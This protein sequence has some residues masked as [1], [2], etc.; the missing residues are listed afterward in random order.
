MN[1]IKRLTF[2]L[3]IVALSVGAYFVK[4]GDTLWD[5]SAEFFND[6]FTWPDLW[7]NNRHIQ[8]PHWIYPGDSIYLGEAQLLSDSAETLPQ[9]KAKPCVTTAADTNLPKGVSGSTGCEGDDRGSSF[10]NMLGNLR[11][12]DK[13]KKLKDTSAKTAHYYQ[14]RPAPKI[15]NSYYQFNSPIVSSIQDL[16]NDDRWFSVSSGE[17]SKPLIYIPESELVVGIGRQIDKNLKKGD[18]IEIWDAKSIEVNHLKKY[19]FEKAALLVPSGYAKITAIGDTLSRAIIVQAFRDI[20]INNIK[21]RKKQ[22]AHYINVSGY[23]PIKEAAIEDMAY[24]RY[25]MDPSLI[26]GAY[27]Y[28]L[29]DKG[30]SSNFNSGDGVAIWEEDRSDPSIPPR[31]LGRG[32]ITFADQESST[33]LI[34]ETYSNSR[35][36]QIGHRVSITHA[37]QRVQ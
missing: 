35:R 7:E 6:P 28:I 36:I 9:A 26:I 37:A 19:G 2:F 21:A 32:V 11:E 16:K 4:K 22:N 30:T 23:K 8:D 17:L 13:N 18:L 12:K 5:L 34:R 25:A 20:R 3:T 10:E 14:K 15:F 24:V 31:L 33:V 29:V 1:H 27:S